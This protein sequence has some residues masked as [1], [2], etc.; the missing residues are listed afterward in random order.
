MMTLLAEVGSA[1]PVGEMNVISTAAIAAVCSLISGIALYTKGRQARTVTIDKQPVGVEV[2]DKFVTRTEFAEFK[3][4]M[5]ADVREMKG[6]YDKCLTLIE[7]RDQRLTEKIGG[8][9]DS[10]TARFETSA[11]DA[12]NRRRDIHEKINKAD[13][14]ITR[15]ETQSDISKHIGKLGS[16]M[17]TALNKC[18]KREG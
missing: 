12:G 6:M 9:T 17:I 5:K 1:A 2:A 18:P 15:I 16:A 7:T 3:G 8:L 11:V 13:E 14:R 10:V 4:E